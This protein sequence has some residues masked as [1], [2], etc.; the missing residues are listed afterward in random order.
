MKFKLILLLVLI[1]QKVSGQ[2]ID[3]SVASGFFEE[4]FELVLSTTISGDIRYTI[5]GSEPTSSSLLYVDPF[6]VKERSNEPNTISIIPTN[7]PTTSLSYVWKMP[8]SKTPKARIVKAAVFN[9]GILVSPI[10]YEE[11]FIGISLNEIQMPIFSIQI[12]SSDLFDYETGIY[13][14]G[15]DYDANPNT[16]QPGN[17]YE[18]GEDWEREMSLTFYENQDLIFRQDTEMQ[19]HGGGSRIRPCKSLRISAKSS[20]GNAFF[21]YPF[22]EDRP[23]SKYK[24]L[25]LRN[26]GQDWNHALFA[27]VLMQSLLAQQNI[28]HQASKQ[29]VVFINGSYWGIH[30]LREKYDKHYFSNYHD[31]DDEAIDYIEIASEFIA[32]EG[33]ALDYELMNESLLKT[34]LSEVENYASIAQRIDVA[35]Y[36]DHHISKVYGGG[37]DWSGNNE[38]LWRTHGEK[39]KWRWVANDYD[40]AFDA[41]EYDS[42]LH[43]TRTDGP[44]WPNPEWSTRL[45]RSLMKNVSFAVQYK[46][47]LKFHLENT[48]STELVV[49]M[50]D[51]IATIYRPEIP[52]QIERWTYPNSVEEWEQFVGEY[53]IFATQ[54]PQFLWNNFL[55]Y[56]PNIDIGPDQIVVYPNPAK[57]YFYI[58]LP[59]S[60]GENSSMKILSAEGRLILETTLSNSLRNKIDLPNMSKGVYFVVVLN[61]EEEYTERLFIY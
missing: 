26:A 49:D 30:N 36:I 25:I 53:K 8:R 17:Y 4:K 14:A 6:I 20:L 50:I 38:R 31:K 52:R 22:F 39:S 48:Y 58:D 11:Y 24:R 57:D 54:R 33:S 44:A 13:V 46:T 3:F 2:G 32:K 34:D 7:P 23:W 28:A 59:D 56:F 43:A 1:C 5:D 27:D 55:H 12:N 16:W 47:R 18:R 42:Y 35:N 9:E 29:V 37:K 51:S 60:F 40:D 61:Q 15:K 19:I 41:I 45:F 21:E 10:L